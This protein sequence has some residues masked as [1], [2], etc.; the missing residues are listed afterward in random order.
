MKVLVLADIHGNWPALRAIPEEADLVVCLGDLV[1]YGPFPKE[2]LAWI[3]ERA[4]YIVRGNHDTALA[5]GI[6]PG[7]AGHK[8]A[9]ARVTLEKHR[10]LLTSADVAWLGGLPVEETFRVDG[11]RFHAVHASPKD[12]LLS[13]QL[14]PELPDEDLRKELEDVRA[15]LV[16]AGHTHLPMSRGAWSKV[17]L[18]PGSVGQPLDGD[19]RASYAVVQDGVAEIRRA[20]Y[21]V[22]ATIAGIRRMGLDVDAG[23]ALAEILR[24]GAPREQGSSPDSNRVSPS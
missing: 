6:E 23:E 14:T 18:N 5:F 13:Y 11:Y 17:L 1:S 16:L 21:D 9:L 8:A 22:E 12:P 2:C 19:P 20:A 15:D 7:A 3:R 4:R 24:S 10:G